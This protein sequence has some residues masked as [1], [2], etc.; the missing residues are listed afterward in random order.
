MD[1]DLFSDDERKTAFAL[2]R[3]HVGLQLLRIASTTKG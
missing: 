2:G 3:R 1:G